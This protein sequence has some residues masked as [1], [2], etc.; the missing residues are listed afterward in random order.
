MP[1]WTIVI[2]AVTW[3]LLT[4]DIILLH[5]HRLHCHTTCFARNAAKANTHT[6][7]MQNGQQRLESGLTQGYWVL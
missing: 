6:Y 3:L 4:K 2:S 5:N 1:P 7:L